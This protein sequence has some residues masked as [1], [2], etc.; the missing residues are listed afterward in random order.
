MKV[1]EDQMYFDRLLFYKGLKKESEIFHD[2][3][4][5]RQ[6]ATIGYGVGN[7]HLYNGNRD[8]AKQV[9][10]RVLGSKEWAAFGFIAAENELARWPSPR[11]A[12]ALK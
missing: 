5:D 9:F 8:R 11:P 10:E 4:D 3:L 7:W 6:K 1:V 2:R 12:R